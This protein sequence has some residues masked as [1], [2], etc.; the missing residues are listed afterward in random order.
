MKENC[1]LIFLHI[2]KAGGTTFHD[3]LERHFK[4]GEIFDIRVL[5]QK[6][7][8]QK[9]FIDLSAEQKKKINLLKGHMEFGLHEQFGNADVTY[10]TFLRSPVERIFSLY[11]YIH[12]R[13]KHYLYDKVVGQKMSFEEYAASDLTEE[14]DNGQ[15]RLIS[16]TDVALGK[17]DAGLLEQAKE[18]LRKKFIGF[19]IVE[20]FDESLILLKNKF[21]WK[22][23]PVYRR[24]NV[25]ENAKAEISPAVRAAIEKRNSFD[26]ELYAWASA[27]FE[28]ELSA[29]KNINEELEI[30]TNQN[31]GFR[32]GYEEGFEEGKNEGFNSGYDYV[33]NKFFVLKLGKK[34]K[35][36]L[37]K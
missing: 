19:G 13:P 5:G 15:V 1:K 23:Y 35:K 28:K 25:T 30:L 8:T 36:S 12:R 26:M 21:G 18:N 9:E 32:A 24:L 22:D 6:Q 4:P 20:R 11:N 17:V 37:G 7:T 34:I 29:I 27:E 33:V 16:G 3:I 10:V 2:P 31:A 14:I